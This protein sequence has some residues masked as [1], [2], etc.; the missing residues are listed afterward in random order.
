[1]QA[2][3]PAWRSLVD[4]ALAARA[5]SQPGFCA[6]ALELIRFVKS[7]PLTGTNPKESP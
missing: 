2:T 7:N 3:Y 4:Q 6:A 5:G 1:M